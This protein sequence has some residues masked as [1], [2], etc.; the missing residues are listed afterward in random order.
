MSDYL[1]VNGNVFTADP[2]MPFARAVAVRGNRIAW[3]GSD[4]GAKAWRGSHTQVVDAG[5]STV[6]PGFIDSHFHL[7]MGSIE[8]AD[9]QLDKAET[10][11]EALGLLSQKEK[12][13]LLGDRTGFS[14]LLAMP[15]A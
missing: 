14:E 12:R 9:M 1:I 15:A 11:D 6:M 10:L 5:G 13:A 7:L 8:A 4:A 2:Q 3:V